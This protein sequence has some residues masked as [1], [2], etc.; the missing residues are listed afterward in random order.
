MGKYLDQCAK[1][2]WDVI[3]GRKK[4]VGN[5]IIECNL[6][7]ENT[8]GQ[9]EK[10]G[11]LAPNGIFYSV[12][13]GNHQ[14]WASQYLLNEYRNGNIELKCDQD[15]GDKL[16]EMGF[17]LLHSPHRYDFFV[18]RDYK[19]RITNKQKEF[20]IDYFEKRN[21]NQWLEKLYQEEI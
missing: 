13:F 2:A 11:W 5:K 9:E 17:I 14:A 10:Y 19:K 15:P 12:E 16:C 8:E 7:D 3:K 20:L 18:T 21:M 1:D 4:I 6:T